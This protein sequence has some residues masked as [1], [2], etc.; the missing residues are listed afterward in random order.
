[1]QQLRLRCSQQSAAN[2]RHSGPRR[3][4]TS[5]LLCHLGF[6]ANQG[7]GCA[8]CFSYGLLFA[9]RISSVFSVHALN[10]PQWAIT[11]RFEQRAAG[12]PGSELRNNTV[13]SAVLY[14]FM[15]VEVPPGAGTDRRPT[16]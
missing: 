6:W 14:I 16:A 9:Y 13:L 2:S 10:T 12:A 7:C 8:L 1:M 3:E 15:E 5:T 4:R 11:A